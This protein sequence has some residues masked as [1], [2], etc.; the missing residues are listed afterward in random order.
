MPQPESAND[1]LPGLPSVV[2]WQT[3]EAHM[4]LMRWRFRVVFCAWQP[5][6][7]GKTPGIFT[8]LKQSS[9]RI[10]ITRSVC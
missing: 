3:S 6:E 4:F 10:A 7:C 1:S 8:P 5:I 2:K 9:E